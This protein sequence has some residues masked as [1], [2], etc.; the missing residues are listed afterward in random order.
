M[1]NLVLL[2]AILLG[3]Y[4]LMNCTNISTFANVSG[5]FKDSCKNISKTHIKLSADCRR[6]NGTYNKSSIS[7]TSCPSS[8]RYG[9]KTYRVKNDNGNLKCE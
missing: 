7:F 5:G 9:V 6:K 4:F 2:L 8:R 3:A 1:N